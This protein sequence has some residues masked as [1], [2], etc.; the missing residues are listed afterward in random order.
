M[1]TKFV[2]PLLFFI[3]LLAGCS[4]SNPYIGTWEG[5][6]DS[7]DPRGAA[8]A[9][10]GSAM[11]GQVMPSVTIIF[12]DKECSVFDGKT[13]QRSPIIYKKGEKGYAVSGDG[14]KTW[15]YAEFKDKDTMIFNGL[16]IS[17]T[18]KKIK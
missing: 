14:G 3:F 13:E 5:K 7:S 4:E 10:L 18:F 8:L 15:E 12:S 17:M 16:G 2:A 11:G 9:M 1:A 6:L